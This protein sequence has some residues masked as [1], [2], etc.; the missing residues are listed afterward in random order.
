M[1]RA[2]YP[3]HLPHFLYVLD[4]VPG[5]I[6]QKAR[7]L[8]ISPSTLRRYRACGQAPRAIHLALFWESTWGIQYIESISGL[9][10][11]TYFAQVQ[12]LERK[13]KRL[14]EHIALLEA[15]LTRSNT[16]PANLPV[17]NIG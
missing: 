8:D 7:L 3:A 2:P 12:A 10:T 9:R 14:V 5:S 15:E 17:F 11:S 16:G 4:N 1:F 6:E 13:N